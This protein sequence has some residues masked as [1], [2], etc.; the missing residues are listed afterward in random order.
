MPASEVIPT[1]AMT[2]MAQA[3]MRH[4]ATATRTNIRRRIVIPTMWLQST[5]MAPRLSCAKLRFGGSV[6]LRI[7]QPRGEVIRRRPE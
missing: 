6:D 3:T 4:P 7:E 2:P 1:K 5:P